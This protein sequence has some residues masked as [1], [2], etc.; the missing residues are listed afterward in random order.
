MENLLVRLLANNVFC[1]VGQRNQQ[2][3]VRPER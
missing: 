2:F 1:I 3:A